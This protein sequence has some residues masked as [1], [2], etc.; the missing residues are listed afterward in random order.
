MSD[1]MDE[2]EGGPMQRPMPSPA[3]SPIHSPTLQQGKM[4]PAA[5]EKTLK[6]SL[7]RITLTT[8]LSQ[9]KKCEIVIESLIENVVRLAPLQG[10]TGCVSTFLW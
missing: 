7:T 3:H 2:G 6:D 10:L 8:E 1:F 4:K 5:A 9:P